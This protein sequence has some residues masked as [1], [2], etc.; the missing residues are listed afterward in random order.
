MLQ[1]LKIW[2]FLVLSI[3]CFTVSINAQKIDLNDYKN[4]AQAY[5]ILSA[6]YSND[7]YFYSRK[8]FFLEST[9][10]IKQNSDTGIV[11]AQIAME[12]AD[13]A[14]K[15][16]ND[17]CEYAKK[18]MLNAKNFQLKAIKIFKQIKTENNPDFIHDLSEKSMYAMGNA[19]TDAYYA[20]LFLG[21]E[22]TV[23]SE[24]V[25][26]DMTRL[27]SDEY[28]YI[29]IKELYGKRLIEIEDE[30]L[31]LKAESKKSKGQKL[32]EINKAIL[33]LK[34]E[35]K[36]I[37]NKMKNSEDRLINV[38]NDLSEEM[39]KVVNK[40]IFTTEKKDFYNENVPVPIN[41]EV[42]KGVVYRVQ[43]GFFKS[44]LP[45]NH[46]TGIFPV[47]SQKVDKIYY[48]Y[49]AGNFEKYEDAKAAK[50]TLVNKGYSDSF[51]VAFINGEKVSIKEALK[52]EKK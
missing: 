26:R 29:T 19:V 14:L 27:E 24:K 16:A 8:N 22:D 9:L 20:S 6:Q 11:C 21:S 51:V 37:M 40:D 52:E 32:I 49:L 31:L 25:E 10:A 28:S 50:I 42:P 43:I 15:L 7:A 34:E 2:V 13:S 47:S 5:A 23:N 46:F 44:Q 17:T 45:E 18:I 41:L 3:F 33:Q 4:K 39:L 1:L 48:R 38:R 12:Y 35:E 30:I 36:E